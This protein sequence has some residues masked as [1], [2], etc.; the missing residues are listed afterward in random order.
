MVI[1]YAQSMSAV[2]KDI[3]LVETYRKVDQNMELR[4]ISARS[5]DSKVGELLV[6]FQKDKKLLILDGVIV[7]KE[8]RRQ[9]VGTY[10]V[11]FAEDLAQRFSAKK[12]LLC[13]FPVDPS[14]YPKKELI[15][16]YRKR[17]YMLNRGLMFKSIK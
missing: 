2:Q 13:P 8:F 6:R 4:C 12:V 1:L 11:S 14:A 7:E 10:L 5:N 15:K 9:G 3:K 16:W 17:G